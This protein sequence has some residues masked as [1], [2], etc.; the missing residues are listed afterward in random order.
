MSS[1]QIMAEKER[2]MQ[3]LEGNGRNNKYAGVILSSLDDIP[4][5]SKI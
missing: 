5:N 2:V 3:Y 4:L 1:L